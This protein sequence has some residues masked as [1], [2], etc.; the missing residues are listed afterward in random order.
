[1]TTELKPCPFCGG[2]AYLSNDSWG[3]T[4]ACSNGKCPIGHINMGLGEW[5]NRPTENKI[6]AE[7]IRE[8]VERYKNNVFDGCDIYSEGLLDYAKQLEGGEL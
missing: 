3:K 2:E 8:A 7:G 4:A 1:M 5:G 6:K